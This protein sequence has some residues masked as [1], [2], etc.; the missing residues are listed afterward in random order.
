MSIPGSGSPLLL[1]TA[2]EA[3]AAAEYVIPKS[4]RFNSGDNAH[5]DK[6]FASEG[7]RRTWTWSGWLK[8][9]K[10][11]QYSYFFTARSASTNYFVFNFTDDQLKWYNR[12]SS[13]THR[14]ATTDAVFRDPA[15][16]YH[17]VL[18]WDTTESTDSDRVKLYVNG[19]RITSFSAS[20]WP[21][22]N[23]EGV[24]N[25]NH[26]HEIG[27][28]DS[29]TQ[30]QYNGLMADVQFVDGQALAATD[31]GETRSSDG[32][33]APKEYTFGT[34]P[35]DGTTWS[36]AVPTADGFR[37]GRAAEDG[38]DGDLSTYVAINNTT[39]NL[40]V[41]SWN[42][43]GTVEVYTG[44]N[45]Q[46]AVDGGSASSMTA[47]D[48]TNVGD[49]GSITTLTFTRTDS[50]YPYFY[51][52]RVGGYV[53][54]D[55]SGDNSFH[56]NF[57]DSSTNEA[58]GF[59]SAPTAPDPDPKKGFDV[60]TYTGNG[61]TQNI[62]GLNFEPALMWSKTR[63]NA[64]DHKLVD[65]VRGVTNVL[66]PNQD[67]ADSTG[68]TNGITAINPD[69]FTVG[70]SGDFN[71]N[72]RT[73]VTWC[74]K[75]GGP[76]VANTD[77]TITSQ[78]SANTDYGFS[79]V[80]YTGNNTAG[81]T[82][83][84]GLG[85]APKFIIAK[86]RDSSS[87]WWAIYHASQGNTKGAYLND[88]QAFSTQT[89][90]NDTTPTSSVFSLGANANT[91]ASGNDFIAYCFSEISNYSKVSSYS[92]SGSAGNKI[93]GLG[94]RPRL[95]ILKNASSTEN[96]LLIDSERGDNLIFANL[97][98]AEAS[99]DVL[100]FTDDGFTLKQTGLASNASG[101]S[102]IY[103]A[104]GDRP[105]NNFDVNNIVTNEGL[106]TSKTQF[107]VVTYSGTGSTQ[108]IDSLAFQ[109]DFVW[110][111]VRNAGS[112][113]RLFDSVRG[114]GK[115]LLS[116][117]NSAEETHLT[118]LSGFTSNGFTLGANGE[119]ATNVNQSSGSYVAWCWKAGGTAVSNTDGSI[120]SSV[121]AN[122]QYGFS[123][124]TYTGSAGGTVGHG[125]GKAPK[126]IIAK[127]RTQTKTW[128][129]YTSVTG[130]DQYLVL[131]DTNA[132][133][134]ASGV[135]GSAEPTSAV[136]GIEN[137]STGGNVHGDIV[138][139]CFADVPGY[140]RIGSV[141][142]GSDPI[143]IT[144]FKPRFLLTK[145]TSGSEHW[146]LHDSERDPD[147]D[148]NTTTFE[149]NNANAEE[150]GSARQVKFLDNGFQLIGGDVD[151]SG[152][153]TIYLAIGDD[154]IGSD[155]DCLVD[156]P[157]AVT[158][159]GDATD[160]TGGY[161]RGN[162]A[163]MNPV[164]Q[165][166]TE[167]FTENG[168]LTVGN[169]SAPSGSS[170]SRGFVPSTIGFKT[171]KWYAEVQTTAASDGDVDFAVGIFPADSTGYYSTSGHYALRPTGHLYSPAGTHQ[172][173]GTGA[174]TDD[175]II[176]IAVD[177]DSSTK[178]IQWFKN[179]TAIASALTI[180]DKEYFFGYGSDGGGGGRTYRATWNFGQMRFKYPIPSGYAALNTTAL[181]AATI[182]D[183]SAYFE[184][185]T[186]T[187]NGTN[188]R[189][190][191][192][193]SFSPDLVWIKGRT[194]MPDGYPYDHSLADTVRGA[195]KSLASNTSSDESSNDSYGYISQFNSDGFRVTA[196]ST[197]DYYVNETDEPY[198]AWAWD[199]G[200]STV[201]NTDGSITS[202]VR[203]SQ[204]AGFSIVA[205]TSNSSAVRTVGHGLNSAPKMIFFKDRDA[206]TNWFVHHNDG[207]T[208]RMFE[209]LNTTNAGTTNLAAMNNTLPSSS[210]FSL[211]SGGYSI[212]PSGNRDMIAYCFS[213]VASYSAMG[214]YEGNNSSDGP[215]VYTGFKVAFLLVKNADASHPW[216]I[217][218]AA[219]SP[220][221]VISKGLQ[222]NSNG[223]EYDTTD[224]VDFLSNGF[225]IKSSGSTE[226]NL[227]GNTYIYYAVAENPFQ[228][229]GGLAR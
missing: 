170:G 206:A 38:F 141:D 178:T 95:V 33:W 89:F 208:G 87:G 140:Q 187:G 93:T 192:G 172:S 125:L 41:G 220:D 207:S 221:N 14:Y 108:S 90:W 88:D 3:A 7:N 55:D 213:P 101:S 59:D 76:A 37:P 84:H 79:I 17:V 2:A 133:Q 196:G 148:N 65:S 138:A 72:G 24:V 53:L 200:S 97:S 47:D 160:T 188:G 81:A 8:R 32:V 159:D 204:T 64:T 105:G 42:L 27:A 96:W 131:N 156:V 117:G 13:G 51:A 62:G 106:T 4:L 119:G 132:V 174:W 121:S 98:N 60:I 92:G 139:Y 28:Y 214:S 12:P 113:H 185:K 128:P 215:F 40:D 57:N 150:S 205:Y 75:A 186:Y 77:G 226:P 154:E 73:F 142:T 122:P 26:H 110:I 144:G 103:I 46:Y 145:K 210:V 180:A 158:A 209:G 74:W 182:A 151:V 66:E 120:T 222:P 176:G 149:V 134:S 20:V 173:Y 49:A 15:A 165:T 153:T 198:I 155:E 22:Q 78:V 223:A 68:I 29:G 36:D 80:S 63:S 136:F 217:F 91:N 181:P 162:Y 104:F 193:F 52:I 6:T 31:F 211:N 229:N 19:E 83:G 143:V 184:A 216:N 199:A 137:S 67:R 5:L 127:S 21:A 164:G 85:S 16:W 50:N 107:D 9:S 194:N 10:F 61:G 130:K 124:V 111:K 94:F 169:S 45:M 54:I 163:T 225:K 218:D 123:I 219:R 157:N 129:V 71:Y 147:D 116:N 183:G 35:N 1:A 166:K 177:M 224:R 34:N 175:D 82:I 191:T 190:V 39:F 48:W 168:N 112:S 70:N 118:S 43:T 109:P 23:E 202:S 171:G 146:F 201:S 195:G 228:A 114:A 135:W 227:S 102:Y 58:L 126:L 11:D 99:S 115:H 86:D 197:Q 25:D 189:D 203:A 56:L 152:G 44:A 100:D 161:Q 69:G 212:N 18:A 167:Y 179:G 30:Y